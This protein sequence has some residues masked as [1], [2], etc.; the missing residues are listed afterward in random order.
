MCVCDSF[1][2]LFSIKELKWFNEKNKQNDEKC[3]REF[4]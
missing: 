3:K 2:Y 1:Y 4:L